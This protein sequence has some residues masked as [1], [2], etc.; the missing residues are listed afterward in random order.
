MPT[1]AFELLAG[2]EKILVPQNYV[3]L[4]VSFLELS[5]RVIIAIDQN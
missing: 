3:R 2:S 1:F 4:T 5:D